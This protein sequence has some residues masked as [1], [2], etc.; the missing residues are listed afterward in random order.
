MHTP[1]NK[2][3][4]DDQKPSAQISILVQLALPVILSQ[5][6]HTFVGLA[7]TLM[8]GRTGNVTALAA[9]ALGNNIF[10]IPIVFA[11]GLSYAVTP[12]VS[13]YLARGE[14]ETC[15]NFLRN[16]FLNNQVWALSIM[17]V[18][19]ILLPFSK[20]LGQPE[21]VLE[22]AVP[23]FKLQVWSLPGIML[24]QT[25]RQFFDG[26]GDTKPGMIVSIAANL[27]NVFLNYLLIFGNHG[28]PELGLFG[29]GISNCISRWIMGLGMMA[30][31]FLDP[32]MKDWRKMPFVQIPD[33]NILKLLNQLGLP[34]ALQFL[35]EVG[36]FTFTSVLVGQMGKESLAA[37]QIVISIASFTYMMSSGIA[38]AASIRVGHFLGLKNQ[39]ML[40]YSGILAFRL[41]ACFMGSMALLLFLG[42]A[43]IPSLFIA[44]AE[45]MEIGSQLFLVAAL[46]QVSD[47]IQVVGL[48]SLRGISDVKIP[49]WITLLAYWVIAI[50]LGYYWG[51][52][53]GWGAAGT[54]WALLVGLSISA[55]F[56][57][58][59]FLSLTKSIDFAQY[60]ARNP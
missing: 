20:A 28:F 59:R 25:F 60:D 41:A 9:S 27:L 58:F 38:A 13:E 48:G 45:V 51:A 34:V 53:L 54:W 52:F 30:W 29:A 33:L 3:S 37:H 17:A 40:R 16:S 22:L 55:I 10:S 57:L 15:H 50:P 49:T 8:V 14:K 12:K 26:L 19:W 36:A 1:T 2:F 4:A 23:F 7:D 44:N 21:A 47:G 46:F 56:M 5:V 35:F 6:S 24:F 43:W 32:K 42:S 11:V 39:P 31:Y 18:L